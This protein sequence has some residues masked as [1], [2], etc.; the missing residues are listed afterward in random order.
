MLPPR[1]AEALPKGEYLRAFSTPRSEIE[2]GPRGS[3]CEKIGGKARAWQW[4]VD[5]QSDF[6]ARPSETSVDTAAISALRPRDR[7]RQLADPKSN[8]LRP[9]QNK[10]VFP[11]PRKVK[12]IKLAPKSCG[13]R[14]SGHYKIGGKSISPG[15][16]CEGEAGE[17]A[18]WRGGVLARQGTQGS[19]SWLQGR[20]ARKGAG[21]GK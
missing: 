19:A 17:E 21:A 10:R 16:S 13:L 3:F 18:G 6:H 4:A 8:H 11:S 15:F 20:Q 2:P 5:R 7:I 1:V 12:E 14:A 9:R